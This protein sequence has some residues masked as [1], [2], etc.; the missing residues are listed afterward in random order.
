MI[1]SAS[2]SG[3]ALVELHTTLNTED[4]TSC[5]LVLHS[6]ARCERESL[7]AFTIKTVRLGK[8][9]VASFISLM[10]LISVANVVILIV[11][12]IP[13]YYFHNLSWGR[14]E[15]GENTSLYIWRIIN[16]EAFLW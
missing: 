13:V 2:S 1:E 4:R 7:P 15:K 16:W 10:P 8:T 5:S 6:Y 12:F 9:N 11:V 3:S 14:G